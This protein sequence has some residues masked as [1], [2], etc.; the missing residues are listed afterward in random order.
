MKSLQMD[1]Q[2]DGRTDGRTDAE[3][4]NIIRPFFKRAYNK[5][6]R[7]IFPETVPIQL[8][9]SQEIQKYPVCSTTK[10]S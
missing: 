4:Y 8:N 2:T 1:G 10:T 9:I 5:N 6:D 3:E 7:V